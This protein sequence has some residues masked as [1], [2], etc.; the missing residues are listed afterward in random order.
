MKKFKIGIQLYSLRDEMEKD[1]FGTLKK[2]K[3]IGYDYVEFAGYFGHTASEVR[4]MLDELDLTCISVHHGPDFFLENGREAVDYLKTIGAKY[5]GIGCPLECYIDGRFD[6]TIEKFK[7][8]AALL[9]EGGIRLTYHNHNYEFAKIGGEYIL[10]KI[11]AE[12]GDDIEGEVDTCWVHYAGIDPSKFLLK[13]SGKMKTM[14]LKDFVCTKLPDGPLYDIPGYP[15][16]AL[17]VTHDE[18]GFLYVPLGRGRQNIPEILDAADRVGIEHVIVEQDFSYGMS[19]L[20]AAKISRDYLK[21]L[22]L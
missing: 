20:D 1:F 18:S 13:Y 6:E 2:V 21:T 9:K 11:Y 3:E 5:C 14:H 8:A 12:L 7:K 16:K 17:S 4:S 15:E 19:C 22:G 10:E